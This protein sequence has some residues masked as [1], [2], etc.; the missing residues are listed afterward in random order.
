[1]ND[2]IANVSQMRANDDLIVIACRSLVAAARIYDGDAT[3]IVLFH[4]AI[5]KA[6]LPQEFH[7]ANLEPDEMV[8]VIDDA[9]LV[10]FRV[11]HADT[12]L[13]YWRGF[14]RTHSPLHR[15]LRFSRNDEMPS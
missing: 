14:L 2:R 8:G 10:S 12:S 9:H 11:A 5:G 1:M 4:I 13:A 3:S 15:G 7:A 6:D